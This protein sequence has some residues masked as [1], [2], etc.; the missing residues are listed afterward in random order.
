M[1]VDFSVKPTLTGERV[2]LRPFVVDDVAAFQAALASEW[3]AH[4]GHP[5]GLPRGAADRI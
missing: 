5:Q 1:P 4:R 2:L 3:A